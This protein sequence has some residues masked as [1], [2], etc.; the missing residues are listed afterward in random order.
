[1]TLSRECSPVD[2]L[3]WQIAFQKNTLWDRCC[4]C[5]CAVLKTVSLAANTEFYL[6]HVSAFIS[7][8]QYFDH[9]V[10]E[11]WTLDVS[12][13]ASYKIILACLS[14]SSSVTSSTSVKFSQN[15]IISFFYIVHDH[16]WPWYLVTD[17]ARF[18][19][20]N[21]RSPSFDP[22]K[23]EVFRHFLEFGSL[24]LH[25]M[26]T[27]N[28]VQILAD[29]KLTKIFF[30]FKGGSK[31]GPNGLKLGPKLG[32]LPFSEVWFVSFP[33]NCIRW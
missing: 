27:W 3:F 1:M 11:F 24:S 2:L 10:Y 14:V 25:T 22:A 20:E 17:E 23:N 6:A 18:L 15:W 4:S 13:T 7:K 8:V 32:S 29:V 21:I 12:Q 16:S 28:N 30:F 26:I 31:F 33:G 19:K 5:Q 9:S